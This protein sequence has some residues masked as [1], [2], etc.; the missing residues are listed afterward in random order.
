[1]RL[2]FLGLVD[3]SV[4]VNKDVDPGN[5]DFSCDKYNHC[6]VVTDG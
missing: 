2:G 5:E 3:T 1:M 4:Q 6:P